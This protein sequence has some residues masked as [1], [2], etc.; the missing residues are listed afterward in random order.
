MLPREL[1][2]VEVCGIRVVTPAAFVHHLPLLGRVL[3]SIERAAIRSPAR[4]FGGFLIV[5]GRKRG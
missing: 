3:P 4:W 1:D 5:I 2:L